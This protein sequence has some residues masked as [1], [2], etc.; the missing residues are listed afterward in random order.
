MSDTC[1]YIYYCVNSITF[2]VAVLASKIIMLSLPYHKIAFIFNFICQMQF[3]CRKIILFSSIY[4]FTRIVLKLKYE[5]FRILKLLMTVLS[6][7]CY[8]MII[9]SFMHWFLV[10]IT[11][12]ESRL[13]SVEN[14]SL[15]AGTVVWLRWI[16]NKKQIILTCKWRT[17]YITLLL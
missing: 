10:E 8:I 13:F 2:K 3:L 17:D 15:S 7:T 9:K 5:C 14:R 16:I 11:N 12:S 6:F 1:I 4:S